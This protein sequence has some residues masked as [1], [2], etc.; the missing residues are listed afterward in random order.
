MIPTHCFYC[1][2]LPG[3][4]HYPNCGKA[5]DNEVTE[6]IAV[7]LVDLCIECGRELCESLDAY[8]GKDAKQGRRC[9]RCRR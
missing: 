2:A 1:G 3:E 6:P 9:S 8:Y 4:G 7:T 5:G